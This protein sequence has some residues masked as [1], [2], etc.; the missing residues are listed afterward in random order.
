M[1]YL[2]T[3]GVSTF[4]VE[5]LF[6]W[7]RC[8]RPPAFDC[9]MFSMPEP[10]SDLFP[11]PPFCPFPHSPNLLLSP[12]AHFPGPL[13]FPIVCTLFWGGGSVPLCCKV[14]RSSRF[15]FSWWFFFWLAGVCGEGDCQILCCPFL[16]G[17][18]EG[19]GRVPHFYQTFFEMCS[20]Y[21][22]DT[23][24]QIGLHTS[25]PLH[26]ARFPMLSA[27]STSENIPRPCLL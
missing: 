23:T 8:P 1:E 6:R 13:I 16:T 21:V 20:I 11:C 17:R 5:C 12:I 14:S 19:R 2:S 26:I 4:T 7:G 18:K 10:L 25:H 27:S 9:E 15:Q 22:V 3:R 24:C